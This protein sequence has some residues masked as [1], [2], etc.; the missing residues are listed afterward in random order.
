MIMKKYYL[1]VTYEICEHD[2][3]YLDMN[4]YNIDS[5]IDLAKQVRG[6]A[7][8]DV[9]PSVKVYESDTT[10]FKDAR[11]YKEY[12]FKEYECGCGGSKDYF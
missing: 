5:A 12:H 10:N 9:A 7:K 11:L 1:A 8:T 6:F 2:N 3:I 4:D